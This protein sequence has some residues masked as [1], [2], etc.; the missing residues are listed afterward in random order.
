MENTSLSG[1]KAELHLKFKQVKPKLVRLLF[2]E[3]TSYEAQSVDDE[4]Y[5]LEN[6][7]MKKRPGC[8][9]SNSIYAITG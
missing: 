8:F 6:F 2:Q 9:A 5:I 7:M 1:E 4:A 3:K